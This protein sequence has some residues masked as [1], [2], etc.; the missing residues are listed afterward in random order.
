MKLVLDTNVVLDW[1]VFEVPALEP[2]RAGVRDGTVAVATNAQAVEE[3]R[4]VLVYPQF[5]LEAD[6]PEAVLRDYLSQ[7]SHASIPEHDALE[8][9]ALPEKFPRCHDPDDDKFLALAYHAKADLLVSKDKAV[10]KLRR[11]APA[12]GFRIV[13]V[14]EMIAELSARVHTTAAPRAQAP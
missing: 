14:P 3:L 2:L 6:A 5:K 4:R 7:T 12:F 8:P 9:E 11:R 10:L 1:L 13:N